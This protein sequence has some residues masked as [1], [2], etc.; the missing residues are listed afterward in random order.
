M[1]YIDVYNRIPYYY[2]LYVTF[3]S[4]EI[5]QYILYYYLLYLTFQS[6]ENIINLNVK[7]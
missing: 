1:N 3:Q 5:E 2:L 4:F 7:F 6:F